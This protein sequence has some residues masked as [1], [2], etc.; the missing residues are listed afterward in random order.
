MSVSLG[1]KTYDAAEKH[2]EEVLKHEPR[3]APA[4]SALGKVY[5]IRDENYALWN[6]YLQKAVVI[7]ETNEHIILDYGI[8]W[9]Y[10][11]TPDKAR[12]AFNTAGKLNPTLDRS[13]LGKTYMRFQL[14][15]WAA[16]EL[17]VGYKNAVEFNNSINLENLLL[18]SE[19]YDQLNR[20]DDGIEVLKYVIEQK[21]DDAIAHAALGLMLLGTGARNY[22]AVHACGLNQREAVKHL[23]MAMQFVSGRPEHA[24]VAQEAKEAL[25][26]CKKEFEEVSIWAKAV[27]SRNG[28]SAG[29]RH[30]DTDH[31]ND[32]N[33]SSNYMTDGETEMKNENAVRQGGLGSKVK[34]RVIHDLKK[35]IKRIFMFTDIC[36][37]S[38]LL[39]I[40]IPP[41][42]KMCHIWYESESA[43][44]KEDRNKASAMYN[45]RHELMQKKEDML[46]RWNARKDIRGVPRTEIHSSGQLMR[47]VKANSPVVVKNFQDTWGTGD[48]HNTFNT[49]SL[50]SSFGD[51]LVRVSVSETGRF[52]GPENGELWGLAE[53]T[54]VLVRPP[55]T[56]MRFKDFLSLVDKHGTN[57]TSSKEVFYLEY[58]SLQQY[59]GNDFENLI[60][61]PAAVQ[62]STELNHLVTNLW[63]GGTPTTS[64]LH[65][66]DYENLLCQVR[67]HKELV[68]FP[69]QQLPYLYYTGRPKG[70][71]H[72]EYPGIFRRD[73]SSID[74]QGNVVFGSGVNVDDPDKKRHPLYFKHTTPYRVLLNPGAC[75]YLPAYW[76]HEVQSL[77]DNDGLNVAVNF[78]FSNLTAP[79]DDV[80]LLQVS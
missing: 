17:E 12:E 50:A 39:R 26:F 47:Y 65:Y 27:Q 31:D 68:L 5:S 73:P 23:K 61:F 59:L 14:F 45:A 40:I 2:F 43:H 80:S 15:E 28:A 34:Q 24:R 74:K 19:C 76:H 62:N 29:N 3:H 1:R 79:V 70:N 37:P 60:P 57:A 4:L 16:E 53:G 6:E 55:T 58:L 30:D 69:P 36:N 78:W 9:L 49:K 71:L 51:Q 48:V 38:K 18:L 44:T 42:D 67:G 33:D 63:I 8:S 66:D 54:D 7:D 56:S 22:G 10:L 25:E 46:A 72:Y 20:G 11:H 77:P 35:N 75:L 52:D 41:L 21:P 32:G 13:F 64:P